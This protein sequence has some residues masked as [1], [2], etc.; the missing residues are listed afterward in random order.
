MYHFLRHPLAGFL[1]GPRAYPITIL[2]PIRTCQSVKPISVEAD[3]VLGSTDIS[4]I[5]PSP[6]SQFSVILLQFQ[7]VVDSHSADY[8]ADLMTEAAYMQDK[9]YYLRKRVLLNIQVKLFRPVRVIELMHRRATRVSNL[10]VHEKEDVT[11]S[12]IKTSPTVKVS[13]P[14]FI[15]KRG[16]VDPFLLQLNQETHFNSPDSPEFIPYTKSMPPLFKFSL[17]PIHILTSD[18]P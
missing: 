17:L 11:N 5:L 14:G 2:W 9:D 4:D 13:C 18:S 8:A 16:R 6:L 7:F 15:Y 12:E 1:P 10:P 3:C